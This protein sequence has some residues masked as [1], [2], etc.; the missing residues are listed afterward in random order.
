MKKNFRSAIMTLIA[1]VM[2][3]VM[4]VPAMAEEAGSDLKVDDL[5]ATI[6]LEGTLPAKAEDFTV[7]LTAQDASNPMP[8]GSVDGVY[9]MTITGAATEIFPEMAFEELG[10]YTYTVE[11]LEGSNKKM[12]SYDDRMFVV[13]V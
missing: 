9:D 12:K 2:C 5:A 4:T 7:R 3:F 1:L 6:T 10:V 11:Q 13:S 8:E